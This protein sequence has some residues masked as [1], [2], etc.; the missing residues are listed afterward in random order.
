MTKLEQVEPCTQEQA[1]GYEGSFLVAG[2][3]GVSGQ[4]WMIS[5]LDVADLRLWTLVLL[6][7]MM[8]QRFY[9]CWLISSC[10]LDF[11]HLV[12]G[13][14]QPKTFFPDA[15]PHVENYRGANQKARLDL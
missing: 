2:F 11:E 5:G 1:G 14:F 3:T 10:I 15:H 13:F 6:S 4:F 12:A 9:I 7:V 8:R